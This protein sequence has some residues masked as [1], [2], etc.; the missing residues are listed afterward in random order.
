MVDSFS[1]C[2]MGNQGAKSCLDQIRR[3]VKP[4]EDGGK[5]ANA[6]LFWSRTNEDALL[7]LIALLFGR[8]DSSTGK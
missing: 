3:L 8:T 4:K 6:T 2:V 1:L 5:S 7:N